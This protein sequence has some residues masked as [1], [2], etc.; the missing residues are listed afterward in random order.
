[1]K[2]NRLAAEDRAFL[3]AVADAAFANPFSERRDELD[4]AI[5]GGAAD[6]SREQ[7]L[8]VV[9]EKV[10]EF[11]RWQ[12]A[13]SRVALTD[14]EP[15]DR[16]LVEQT[17]LFEMFHRYIDALDRL[18]QEQQAKGA[19]P[20]RV[21][22]A[23]QVLSEM[24]R[25]GMG[26]KEARIYFA[27][28]YQLRRAYY[29]LSTSLAGRCPSLRELRL[30]LWNNVFTRDTR[31]YVMHL[32]DR[33]EDFSTLLLGETGTGKGAAASA[34]GRSG[35][36]P[37][38]A[39]RGCF[40]ESFVQSFV[41]INL[42]QFPE[43][44]IESELFGHKKGAFTGAMEAHEGV[45]ARCSPHGAIFLDEIGDVSIPTQIK[46]LKVLQDREFSPVGSHERR[47]FSGRVIAASNRCIDELR[48]RKLFRDDFFYRLCSDLIEVPPLRQRLA[49]DPGELDDLLAVTLRRILGD[50]DDLPDLA[51]FVKD[52]IG[53]T[54]GP[55]YAWPGN[56]RELEQCVRRI[57]LTHTYAG[58]SRPRQA[59][60]DALR[61]GIE[62][63]TLT[64]GELLRRYCRLLYD[65][66]GTYEE[67]ARITNL[68]R[69]TAKKYV[70]EGTA[71]ESKSLSV[72]FSPHSG[73]SEV[74]DKH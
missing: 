17:Y 58:D 71:R 9:L 31:R 15:E 45:F 63:G 54:L 49:E 73:D 25:R 24:G 56:V 27:M 21:P 36:I 23:K 47:R 8:A 12:D 70:A 59:A 66:H 33:M 28:F 16:M 26:V 68:D 22:F 19:E 39:E 57:L 30:A 10:R 48:V 50:V 51:V 11:I 46:L 13:E 69:R 64:A 18:I 5:A 44:L 29:F 32:W 38:D 37:Y 72:D 61:D 67:V 52:A 62:A 60:G 6:A 34:L 74:E 40:T 7:N 1:M 65:R 35:F 2:T 55:D 14:F 42:S 4:R 3:E 41:A 20:L 53:R 43:G